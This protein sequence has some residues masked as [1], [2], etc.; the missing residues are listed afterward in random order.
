MKCSFCWLATVGCGR[1]RLLD[2]YRSRDEVVQ[3]LPL[4][5]EQSHDVAAVEEDV[6]QIVRRRACKGFAPRH[7]PTFNGHHT[8]TQHA[9]P[10]GGLVR[11]RFKKGI[12]HTCPVTITNESNNVKAESNMPATS[13][14]LGA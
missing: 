11:P 7:P 13:S 8:Q 6:R 12:V 2:D 3:C 5:R 14:L 1:L 4:F 10:E 9:L